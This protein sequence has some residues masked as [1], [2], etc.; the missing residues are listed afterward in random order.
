[1]K[2]YLMCYQMPVCSF[3]ILEDLT[4]FLSPHWK[5]KKSIPCCLLSLRCSSFLIGLLLTIQESCCHS[6]VCHWPTCG[7]CAIMSLKWSIPSLLY[8][9]MHSYTRSLCKFGSCQAYPCLFSSLSAC[10]LFFNSQWL[11]AIGI[12]QGKLFSRFY[13]WVFLSNWEHISD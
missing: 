5:K 7:N 11:L 3:L 12:L 9:T 10:K 1:M 13:C 6:L 2:P 8:S 4:L